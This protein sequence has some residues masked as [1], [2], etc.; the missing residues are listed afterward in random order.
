MEMRTE[1]TVIINNS[2]H[3]FLVE[4]WQEA[5]REF[6]TACDQSGFSVDTDRQTRLIELATSGMVTVR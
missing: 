6:L 3:T 4:T 5:M 2:K 1:F